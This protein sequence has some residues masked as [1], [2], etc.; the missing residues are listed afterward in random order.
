VKQEITL[1]IKPEK[2]EVKQL[3]LTL[4]GDLI[5]YVYSVLILLW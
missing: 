4:T 2:Q 1:D 3:W 5:R